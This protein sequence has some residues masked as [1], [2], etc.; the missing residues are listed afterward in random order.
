MHVYKGSC[1]RRHNF[2]RLLVKTSWS[3]IPPIKSHLHQQSDANH[4]DIASKCLN[5]Q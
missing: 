3:T 5:S 1:T 2:T 4:L